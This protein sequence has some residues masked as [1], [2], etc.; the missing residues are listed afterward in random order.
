MK[1]P[2]KKLKALVLFFCTYTDTKFLGKVKLMKLFYFA[3][4]MHL[5]KYG[6]PMTFDNYVNLEH[7]PIPSSIKN[8]VDTATDDVDNSILADTITIERPEGTEMCRIIGLRKFTEN[9]AKI[10]TKSELETLKNV[11]V[12]FGD[13]NT[14]FIEDASHEEAPWQKTSFLDK[15]PYSL[16]IDDTDCQTSKEELDLLEEALCQK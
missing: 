14:K 6:I 4:F 9:D 5:K 15:I 8:L 10:F 7:G 12:R 13:K 11:C 16:A 1:I 2:I 3:D